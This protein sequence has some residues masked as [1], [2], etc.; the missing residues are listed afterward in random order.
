MHEA[1]E[2]RAFFEARVD[3]YDAHM[4]ENVEGASEGY[5]RVAEL[6]PAGC[7]SLLDLGCGTGLELEAVF[8]RFPEIQVTGIDLTQAMLDKLTQKYG[9]RRLTLVCGDYSSVDFGVG[10]YDAAISFQTLHHFTHEEKLR[11][12]RRVF[13]S[14]LP[15]G[16]Y[17]EADYVAHTQEQEDLFL[18][19]RARK[20]SEM[21]GPEGLWHLDIPCT[22]ENQMR[23]LK[24]SV[25][26]VVWLDQIIGNTAVLVAESGIHK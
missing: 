9:N 10:R 3:G 4:L 24:E 19:E 11:L 23:L 5:R 12:Y 8:E 20:L 6:L 1:E 2:M 17:V 16:V 14:L 7:H 25:F 26:S 13:Q 21:G 18:A 22:V 15:G